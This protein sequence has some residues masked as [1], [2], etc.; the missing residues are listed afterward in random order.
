MSV[1]EFVVSI[2]DP[3]FNVRVGFI[4]VRPSCMPYAIVFLCPLVPSDSPIL[5]KPDLP[6]HRNV[7][8]LNL[9]RFFVLSF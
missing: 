6:T 2:V 5:P 4:L 3:F 7:G 9:F 8:H 1:R